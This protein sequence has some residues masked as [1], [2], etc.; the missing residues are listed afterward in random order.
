VVIH[1][2]VHAYDLGVEEDPVVRCQTAYLRCTDCQTG[3][4]HAFLVAYYLMTSARDT[5]PSE[6][7]PDE[8]KL[9]FDA[10]QVSERGGALECRLV[11]KDVAGLT[12]T[13]CEMSKGTLSV[14]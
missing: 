2:R 9:V 13:A 4:A 10:T 7:I 3:A 11:G 8:E 14:W 5:I 1:S 6:L 12:G